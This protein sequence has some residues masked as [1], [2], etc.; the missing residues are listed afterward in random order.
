MVL[1]PPTPPLKPNT[2]NPTNKNHHPE[3]R[4][5]TSPP[6]R[7]AHLIPRYPEKPETFAWAIAD[8]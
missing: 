4:P 5:P 8:H 6:G 2:Q 3:A 7:A 1:P